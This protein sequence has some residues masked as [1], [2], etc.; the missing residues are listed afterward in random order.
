MRRSHVGTIL[1]RRGGTWEVAERR[2]THARTNT[3]THTAS[4]DARM[5][6]HTRTRT[7]THTASQQEQGC[8]LP[9]LYLDHPLPGWCELDHVAGRYRNVRVLVVVG[10]AAAGG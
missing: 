6:A 8:R 9:W 2:R 4:E 5:R 10:G 1:G 7:R 3:R